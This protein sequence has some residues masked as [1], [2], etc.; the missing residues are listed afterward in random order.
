MGFTKEENISSH[1]DS[2]SNA[3]WGKLFSLIPIIESSDKFITE[4]GLEMDGDDPET[5]HITPVQSAKI[6]Y[7][8]EKVMY[9]L[10][11]VIDFNWAN[12]NEGEKIA[13]QSNFENLESVTLLK[14][15]TAFIR[16]N[17][18]SDGALA[19][20]FK[21]GTIANILKELQKNH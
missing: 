13:S 20:R 15:L 5:M 12:W 14:L 7:D 4:G 2:L 1:I 8:F 9:D 19:G 16:N 11:L 17:R 10:G 6:V 3:D 18:F 21:D